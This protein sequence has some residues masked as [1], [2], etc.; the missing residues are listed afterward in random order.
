MGGYG[1][2]VGGARHAGR[3]KPCL[4]LKS[5]NHG[6]CGPGFATWREQLETTPSNPS[7]GN[8]TWHNYESDVGGGR[9]NDRRKILGMRGSL[10][11][12]IMTAQRHIT[13]DW[14]L[15]RSRQLRRTGAAWPNFPESA[16]VSGG[17]SDSDRRSG[18]ARCKGCLVGVP[19]VGRSASVTQDSKFGCRRRFVAL[20]S[21]VK[22][23]IRRM[24]TNQTRRW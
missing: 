5:I 12:I 9:C 24:A 2:A 14:W 1:A 11:L 23:W 13:G 18:D 7:M 3:T 17:D 16:C 15:P 22:K 6:F 10:H 8:R 19:W 20:P 4:I 21:R